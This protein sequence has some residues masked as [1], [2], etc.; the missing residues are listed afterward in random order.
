MAARGQV[1]HSVNSVEELQELLES[2][3]VGENV[4]RGQSVM[5]SKPLNLL[6]FRRLIVL[7][8]EVFFGGIKKLTL[9]ISFEYFHS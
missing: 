2:T 7:S 8:V 9:A 6:L 3:I 5:Q 1:H 4:Q